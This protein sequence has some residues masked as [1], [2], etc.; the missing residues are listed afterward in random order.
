MTR[1]YQYTFCATETITYEITVEAEDY[2]KASSI[3]RKEMFPVTGRYPFNAKSR[4]YAIGCDVECFEC[5]YNEEEDA[6]S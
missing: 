6:V 4:K 3:A 2:Y 1:K 5:T